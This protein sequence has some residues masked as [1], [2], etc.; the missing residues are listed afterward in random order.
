MIL[1]QQGTLQTLDILVLH[2]IKGIG[3]KAQLD[4]IKCYKENNLNSLEDLLRLDSSQTATIKRAVKLLNEFFAN[5][6]YEVAKKECENDLVEW[7]SSGISVLAFGSSE[8]P[9]QLKSLGDPPALLFC[10]GN[11]NLLSNPKSIAVVGTRE[12]TKLGEKIACKTVEHYSNLGFC[13]VSGLAHGIDSIAHRAALENNAKTIAVLVDIVNVSPPGNRE[14]AEQILKQN[15][16]LISENPPGTKGVPGL[17]VKRDRI[18][19]GLSMAVFAIETSI[20]GGTMHAVKTA[21]SIKRDV[22]VPDAVAA[23]YPD[24]GI[25]AISGTQALAVEGRAKPYTRDSYDQI[26]HALDQL[27]TSFEARPEERAKLL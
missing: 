14:L 7:R 3:N 11:L 18:Q 23:G 25:R 26:S 13:I 9:I 22:Y 8:Y 21:L 15:G 5:N 12:N 4:L 1:Q 6:L 27:A 17:F 24:L 16:L 19:A 10:K 20:N 2:R